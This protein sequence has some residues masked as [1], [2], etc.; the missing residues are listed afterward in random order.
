[1]CL[2]KIIPLSCLRLQRRRLTGIRLN[3]C[4]T[5]LWGGLSL[6]IWA[7]PT[8]NTGYEPKFCLDVSS[9]HTPINLPSRKSSFNLETDATLATAEDFWPASTF[10]SKQQP[11]FGTKHCSH[12]VEIRFLY[13]QEAGSGRGS[14]NCCEC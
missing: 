6:A 8:P 9:E 11:A 5:P 10:T 12:F 13:H 4:A 14:R 7:D 2:S 3:P 1:M